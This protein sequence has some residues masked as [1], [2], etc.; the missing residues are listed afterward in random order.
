MSAVVNN[1]KTKRD[2]RGDNDSI[3]SDTSERLGT[4]EVKGYVDGIEKQD[5]LDR[6]DRSGQN[7]PCSSN[8][9]DKTVG[10]IL[11]RLKQL[12]TE[13][14][15]YLEDHQQKFEGLRRESEDRE[16]NFRESVQQLEQDIINLMSMDD[17]N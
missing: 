13:Y 10:K 9:E 4:P 2:A 5:K 6:L 16:S 15:S 17:S 1:A 3:F 14:I 8:G 7:F 11:A 12:E